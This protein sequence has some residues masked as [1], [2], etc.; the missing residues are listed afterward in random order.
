MSKRHC[1]QIPDYLWKKLCDDASK[2]MKRLK[3]SVAPSKRVREIIEEH[4]DKK[5]K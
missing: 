1:V 4:F 3:R 2:R 5:E